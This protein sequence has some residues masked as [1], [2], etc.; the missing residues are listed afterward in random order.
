MNSETILACLNATDTLNQFI[1]RMSLLTALSA[2]SALRSSMS[3]SSSTLRAGSR[4]LSEDTDLP[5]PSKCVEAAVDMVQ[6]ANERALFDWKNQVQNAMLMQDEA[7]IWAQCMGERLE[8][9]GHA[10]MLGSTD[11]PPSTS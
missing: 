8:A 5:L 6:A 1:S 3:R 4:A 2:N 11:G 9:I 7:A 10:A